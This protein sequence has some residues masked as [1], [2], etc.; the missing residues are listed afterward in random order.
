MIISGTVLLI[1]FRATELVEDTSI[2]LLN[3]SQ[4]TNLGIIEW[5]QRERLQVI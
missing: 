5:I 3:G 4:K 2:V 1:C